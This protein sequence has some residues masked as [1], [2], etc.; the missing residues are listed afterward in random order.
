[1]YRPYKVLVAEIH[2]ASSVAWRSHVLILEP[3][4]CSVSTNLAVQFNRRVEG[5][6]E[7]FQDIKR[8]GSR[9]LVFLKINNKYFRHQRKSLPRS[10]NHVWRCFL[11][12]NVVLDGDLWQMLY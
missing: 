7:P 11:F 12:R 8:R 6:D 3:Y 2:N 5:F 9:D 4:L 1:M 10:F